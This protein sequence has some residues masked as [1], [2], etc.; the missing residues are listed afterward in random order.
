MSYAK[1]SRAVVTTSA[2]TATAK[3]FCTER[4]RSCSISETHP[5]LLILS[6]SFSRASEHKCGAFTTVPASKP[7]AFAST[8]DLKAAA[9][10]ALTFA[11][12]VATP[13]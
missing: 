11:G 13:S 9:F 12:V 8:H 6:Y 10:R 2:R 7:S 4:I 3:S 1:S 5:P